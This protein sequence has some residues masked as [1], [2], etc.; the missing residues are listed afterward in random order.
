MP[1]HGNTTL[2]IVTSE[3]AHTGNPHKL[4]HARR[5]RDL[6]RTRL[7]ECEFGDGR[8]P[9]ES[10][11]MSEYSTGRNVIR[12]ALSLLQQEEL[13]CRRQGAGTF[14]LT[15]KTRLTLRNANGFTSAIADHGTEVFSRV[16]SSC[17]I[18]AP[19]D[20]ARRLGVEAGAICLVVEVATSLDGKPAVLLTSYIADP[21]ARERL[22]ARLRGWWAGDWYE[23]L[24]I[25]DLSPLR[26]ETVVEAVRADELV[27]PLLGVE[28]GDPLIR[29]ER[30]LR[31][32]DAG[33]R[34]CGY[35]Y[36]RADLVVLATSD[37]ILVTE[38][39]E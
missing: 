22:G 32:G 28:Q 27:G 25:V 11:L 7:L 20:V 16:V 14:S 35:S 5:V 3:P 30:M 2:T 10:E 18:S 8:L 39:V 1:K 21:E 37:G 34:E 17:E 9:D 19:V 13:I 4:D 12:S 26:R 33:I 29:F 36:C 24:S 15:R 6:L 38:V 31:L 23:L